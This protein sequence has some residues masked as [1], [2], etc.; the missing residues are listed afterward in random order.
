MLEKKK[1]KF[2]ESYHLLKIKLELINKVKVW[3]KEALVDMVEE[4]CNTCSIRES[5][6]EALINRLAAAKE[7]K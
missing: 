2:E 5:D 7:E 4:G 1:L 6:I 3:G